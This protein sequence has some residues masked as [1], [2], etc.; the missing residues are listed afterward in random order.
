MGVTN[1]TKVFK[2]TGEFEPVKKLKLGT[3]LKGKRIAVDAS[4]QEYRANLP[5]RSGLVDPNGDSSSHIN[6]LMTFIILLK[7]HGAEQFW[8][9]DNKKSEKNKKN[10]LEARE[11]KRKSAECELKILY[12]KK[13]NL[14]EKKNTDS[15]FFS[16]ITDEENANEELKE[17]ETAIEKKERLAFR[18]KQKQRDD[19]I[20]ILNA[21]DI[22]YMIAPEGF[23]AEQ[24]CAMSTNDERIFGVKMDYVWTTD[25][26]AMAFGARSMIKRVDKVVPNKKTK[27]KKYYEFNLEQILANATKTIIEYE[28]L[29]ENDK[30]IKSECNR[31]KKNAKNNG[32]SIN[33]KELKEIIQQE[34]LQQ[35]KQ[36]IEEYSQKKEKQFTLHDLVTVCLILGNDYNSGVKGIGYQTVL[37]V[38][39]TVKLSGE[40]EKIRTENFGRQLSSEELSNIIVHNTDRIPFSDK[41]KFENFLDVIKRDRGYNRAR[42]KK[43]FTK[44]NLFI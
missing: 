1:F 23:A 35:N 25:S 36:I 19:T 18:M 21:L 39:K 10:E 43:L 20:F 5:N 17:C 38:Y 27:V 40:Q 8:V 29:E 37:K 44:E 15:D 28:I 24:I 9:I 42:A 34:I 4:I 2:P 22:P 7:A 33:A 3:K 31:R 30:Y 13:K 32:E 11:N 12:E 16:D 6:T 26:D 14:C 41:E